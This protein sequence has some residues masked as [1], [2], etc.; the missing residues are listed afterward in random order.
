MIQIH[1]GFSDLQ[2][3]VRGGGATTVQFDEASTAA[4]WKQNADGSWTVRAG[5]DG[6][7]TLTGVKALVFTDKTI[8]LPTGSPPDAGHA[9]STQPPKP[10]M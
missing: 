4:R 5:T 3:T 6:I 2:V 7:E 8:T 1:G 9:G 10:P